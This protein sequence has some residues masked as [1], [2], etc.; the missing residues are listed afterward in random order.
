MFE[1]EDTKLFESRAI[2]RYLLAKYDSTLAL[3]NNA[4]DLGIFEQADSVGYSYFD[5]AIVD[6]A[7]ETI[8]KRCVVVEDAIKPSSILCLPVR[9]FI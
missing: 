8:F 1:Q 9:D 5:P 2:C 7:Y 6:L 3:P 4:E